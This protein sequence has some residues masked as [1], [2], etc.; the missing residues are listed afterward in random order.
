MNAVN[1]M[2]KSAG[3]VENGSKIHIE[4]REIHDRN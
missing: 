3:S 1:S 4:R 2:K